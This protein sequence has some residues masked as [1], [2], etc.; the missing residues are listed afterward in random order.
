MLKAT[1]NVHG[2]LISLDYELAVRALGATEANGL[3]D[4][5]NREMKGTISTDD[6]ESVVLAGLVEKAR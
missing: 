5:T 6:G 3:P 4:I 2:K 1:P